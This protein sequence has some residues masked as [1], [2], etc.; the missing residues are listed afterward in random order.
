MDGRADF[1]LLLDC[2]ANASDADLALFASYGQGIGPEKASPP[3]ISKA[4]SKHQT[5][6]FASPDRAW[7]PTLEIEL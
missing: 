1:V 3:A 2:F 5:A 4:I 7:T 6:C